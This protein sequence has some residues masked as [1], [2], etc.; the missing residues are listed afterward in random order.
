M[1]TLLDQAS[2]TVAVPSLRA[3]LEASTAQVQW[4]LA[5]YSLTFG[6]VLVSAGRLGDRWGRKRLLIAGITVFSLASSVGALAQSATVLILARLAQGLAAG[7][8]NPQ[9]IGLIQDTYRGPRRARALGAYASTAAL[10]GLLGPLV[11]GA[12]IAIAGGDQGWR[13]V[14]AVNV[15]VGLT[16]AALAA[17]WLPARAPEQ[18]HAGRDVDVVG[19]A[20][21]GAAALGLLLAVVGSPLASVPGW[22]WTAVAA[23]AVVA[24]VW[25]ERRYARGGRRPVM[26]PELWRSRPFAMGTGVAAFWFGAVL[27]AGV[28]VVL[29]LQEG[30]GLTPLQAGLVT[31]PGA[32]AS[33]VAA[34]VSH[35]LLA[36]HGRRLVT[37]AL[38]TLILVESV[39]LMATLHAPTTWLVPA[40]V[41]L[42]VCA[43]AS[44]GVVSAPNQALTLDHAPV[45][46]RGLAAGFFQVSQRISSTLSIAAVTG[47]VVA[48]A[49]PG[50][51]GSYREALA[52]GLGIVIVMLIASV[53]CSLLARDH[54]GRPGRSKAPGPR[55]RREPGA[56]VEVS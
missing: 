5:A 39:M 53:V 14:L 52:R 3:S 49:V 18:L 21:L 38:A 8:A 50:D 16:T 56:R 40:I 42:Q 9:V 30:L 43:G 41:G 31:M 37:A 25:W 36:R 10:S 19:Q 44:G 29:A 4:I 34:S 55:A 13:L 47:V 12:L 6:M 27:A 24:L 22:A 45:A 35:R 7:V 1:A 17:W 28:V 15:P 26:L 11:G 23:A 46:D 32:V 20:L 33:A 54:W 51:L 2:L 48:V